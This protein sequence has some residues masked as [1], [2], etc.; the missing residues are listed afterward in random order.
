MLEALAQALAIAAFVALAIALWIV[1]RKAGRLI[2]ET[3]EIEGFRRA[4]IDLGRRIETSLEG[5]VGRI[6]AVRRHT[7][8]AEAIG[9][10]LTAAIDAVERYADEARHLRGP[11][12]TTEI[13]DAIVAELDRARRALEMVEHGCSILASARAGGRELEAQTA[14]KRGYLNVLHA[15]EAI[16]RQTLRAAALTPREPRSMSER[17]A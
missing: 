8:G 11:A 15:R 16:A 4:V 5:V 3:R 13:R 9:E 10:N 2:A 1:L 7:L 17:R 6:D 12:A 14:I